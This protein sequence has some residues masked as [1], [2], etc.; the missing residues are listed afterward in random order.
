MDRT[1]QTLDQRSLA[2]H[3]LIAEKIKRNP[4]LFEKVVNTLIRWKSIVAASSQ[5]YVHEWELLVQQ[6]MAQCLSVATEESPRA[7]ALRQSSPF[8]GILTN[9]ERT[10]FFKTWRPVQDE[11]TR[12]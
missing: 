12:P 7:T 1:H 6:G 3:R 8:C 2:L 11:T 4:M 9:A 10:Q 5:P